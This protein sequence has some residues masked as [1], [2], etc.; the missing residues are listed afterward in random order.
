[1]LLA[2]HL[3]KKDYMKRNQI[4]IFI[5]SCCLLCYS[6][7]LTAQSLGS[8]GTIGG[9]ITDPSGA[10]I[11]QATID[12]RNPISGYKQT[13][14]SDSAGVFRF[15]NIPPN[16]YHLKVSAAGF[17]PA[18][19]D[20]NV[21]TSVPLILN[22][23]LALAGETTTVNVEA[24]GETLVETDPSSHT[25]VSRD[26]LDKL[27]TLSP[28]NGLNQAIL[29]SSPSVAADSNGF[30]HPLGDHAEVSYN[31]DG[32]PISD[33]QS[34]LFSTQIPLN[35]I[36]SLE[37]V[38]GAPNA[39][40]GDKTSLVV[41]ATTRSGLGATKM[42]GSL[43]GY[44]ASFGTYG[45]E[46]T[47]GFGTPRFGNFLVVDGVRSGRFLDSPEFLPLHDIGQ[48]QSIFDR[49]DFQISP[50]DVLHLNL[51][52]ARNWFQ[53]PNT[54]DQLGQDQRQR[55]VTFN[56]APGYQ[57][58]FNAHTLF[59]VN[60]F[61]RRDHLN[62]YPSR[63]ITNDLPAT[64]AQERFLTNYGVKAD[65][66]YVRSGHNIKLGTQIMQTRLQESFNLGVTDPLFNAVC[67]DQQGNSL[68]LPGIVNPSRCSSG[69]PGFAAN[70]NFNAGLLPFDLSRGGS[71]FRFNGKKNINQ[72]AFYLQDQ[73]TRGNFTFNL[74]LRG[75]L[76]YG[77]VT[78]SA[79]E[80]R[81]GVSYL[82]KRTKTVLRASYSRT[83]ETPYNENLILSSFTGS[84][85]LATNVFGA[86]GAAPIK[87]GRRNQ[88]N[89][90]M[91]QGIG[92]FVQID[93]DYFWKYTQNAY[94]FDTLF[95]TPITFPITWR[96]SKIDGVGVRV[97]TTDLKG[98]QVFT[99]MGHTRARY[100]GPEVGGVIFNS[101]LNSN[102]FRIDHDQAFQQTTNVRYQ[103]GKNGPWGSFTWRYD[104]GLVAAHVP[105][106][107]S[108]LALTG[109][110]QAAIGFFCGN[111]FAS[112]TNPI[113]ACGAGAGATR[114]RIPAAGTENDDTNPPRVS[115]RNLLD[116]SMGTD[117]LFHHAE[118]MRVLLHF[119]VQNLTNT[120]ALYNFLSTFSGTHFVQPR[121]YQVELGLAF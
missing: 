83:F 99:T 88:Y 22:I 82:V 107:S 4:G 77:L 28:G 47:L 9:T 57:H 71:L 78:E 43:M 64:I 68:E 66:S 61:I 49:L 10:V 111:V 21:R 96:Q 18:E 25:D 84:G 51:L 44:A 103:R 42:F 89:T 81:V 34:K 109:A 116:A 38:T 62:Y 76:Y 120:V 106:I 24:S 36:N 94:D 35:A 104:S 12:I 115:A 33:Q 70:P 117:N 8:A 59:T 79:A 55:V 105:D 118:G 48:N 113:S 5:G 91:Q 72:Y 112:V 50:V 29:Y 65:L 11:G 40:F 98:F 73:I 1:L 6:S 60:P 90:G 27:P 85:G 95:S 20:V 80:P 67:V 2:F 30:F 110:Q 97:S 7:V 87:P 100:F 37:L 101:P 15:S 93:A 119:T 121:T 14:K 41:D 19:Q 86:L 63:D 53:V 52:V 54:Y 75:D 39:E 92:K 16:P 56:I 32:Q 31:I 114:L 23:P 3:E 102:V 13:T 58:T 69:G 17:A 74:G 45:E 46:A 26:L 108:A